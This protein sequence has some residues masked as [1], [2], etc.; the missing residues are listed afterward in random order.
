[1]MLL[2]S[3]GEIETI[4]RDS[5]LNEQRVDSEIQNNEDIHWSQLKESQVLMNQKEKLMILR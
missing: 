1:M 4:W 5:S 3:T 2:N